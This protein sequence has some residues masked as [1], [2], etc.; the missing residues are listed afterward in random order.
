[1]KRKNGFTLV[2][3]LVVIGIISVLIS[4]LLPALNKAR[5]AAKKIAC[6]SNMRQIGQA[7]MMYAQDNRSWMPPGLSSSVSYGGNGSG[8]TAPIHVL[9]NSMSSYAGLTLLLPYPWR[10]SGIGTAGYLP[11]PDVLF[12]PSDVWSLNHRGPSYYNPSVQGFALYAGYAGSGSY[13]YT[14]YNYFFFIG[15][16]VNPS[17]PNVFPDLTT[18]AP[19]DYPRYRL[20]QNYFHDGRSASSTAILSDQNGYWPPIY[21]TYYINHKDGWN[22]LYMDGHVKFVPF[23]KS[24]GVSWQEWMDYFDTHG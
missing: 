6:A 24:I 10:W 7:I 22:V 18:G 14:S 3:L 4:I 19:F 21:T 17:A 15:R 16:G 1:M 23:P 8:Y 20:D 5:E 12:C 11:N 2:E 9:G 13:G